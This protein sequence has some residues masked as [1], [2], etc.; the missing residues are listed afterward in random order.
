[1]EIRHIKEYDDKFAISHIYEESWKWAYR[2]IIPKSYLESIPAG[3]WS[4]RLSDF[5]GK[6]LVMLEDET[7]IGTSSCCE[8]RLSEFAGFGE[9]VSIYLLPEYAGMGYGRQLL[10]AAVNEL[11]G[12]GYRDIYL[13]VLEDN[14]RARDFYQKFGFVLS[15]EYLDTEIGGKKLR[16]LQYRYHVK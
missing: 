9:I 1:M 2:D 5:R 3:N 4:A 13:W 6:T 7:Y 15:D 14:H 11:A 16:E 10:S 8:S 12:L